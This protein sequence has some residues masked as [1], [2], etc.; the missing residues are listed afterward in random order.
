MGRDY[1]TGD[2]ELCA[3]PS[4]MLLLCEVKPPP[5]FVSAQHAIDTWF[6]NAFPED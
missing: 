1:T 3:S 6:R 5:A 2:C 4:D